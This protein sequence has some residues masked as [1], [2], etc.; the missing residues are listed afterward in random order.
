MNAGCDDQLIECVM[1]MRSSPNAAMQQ[2]LPPL[3]TNPNNALKHPK[4]SH[5][6]RYSAY[7]RSSQTSPKDLLT[8]GSEG[9]KESG[10]GRSVWV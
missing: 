9:M 10:E 3:P 7:K 4:R 5:I 1:R 8:L 6:H 2:P